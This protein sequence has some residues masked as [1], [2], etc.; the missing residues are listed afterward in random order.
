MADCI[1]LGSGSGGESGDCTADRSRVLAS[2]TAV[3]RD[4]N[5]DQPGRVKQSQ[6][7]THR[8]ER[9]KRKTSP[10]RRRALSMQRTW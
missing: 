2:Y 8:A 3:T 7:A 6:L 4:S 5:D 9:W 10:L 1:I